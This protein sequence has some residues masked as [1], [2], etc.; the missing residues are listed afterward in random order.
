MFIFSPRTRIIAVDLETTGLSITRDRIVELAAVC[1]QHGALVA[2]FQAL[3]HPGRTIPHS[4]TRIHG[5]T[6]EMVRDQPTVA[7]MLPA[8]LAFCEGDVV[9]AH[10]APFDIG[11]LR[12]AAARAEIPFFTT[13][14]EDT[15]TLAKERLPGCPNYRLETL[16]AVLHLGRGQE[17]RALAD[18]HDCLAIYL[19]CQQREAPAMHLPVPP[20]PPL[21]PEFHLLSLVFDEGGTLHIEYEDTRGRVTKREVRPLGVST[22]GNTLVLEAHCLLR[23]EKRHFSLERIRRMWRG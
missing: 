1:W 10:N 22:N 4:A 17:H 13:P 9:V 7:E 8:F 3:V 20:Q 16:K 18:A 11:F 5:I 6:D 12:S 2:E 14:V 21:A 23:N 19:A 15:C